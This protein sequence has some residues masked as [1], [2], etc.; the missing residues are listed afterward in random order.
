MG[1]DQE[2]IKNALG[3]AEY[4]APNLPMM[5]DIDHPSM[6][7]HGIG[8]GAMNGIVSAQLAERGF[9]G[10]P[11]ILV[12]YNVTTDFFFSGH[13]GLAVLGAVELARAG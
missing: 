9:T 12:T 5:R 11:S 1:L 13:T 4:H 8:W 10:V 6:V 3:I 7:K 2:T